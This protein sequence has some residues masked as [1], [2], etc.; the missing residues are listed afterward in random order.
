MI[1]LSDRDLQDFQEVVDWKTG[2]QMPDGRVLGVEGKR[3]KVS[4]GN[5]SRV[6]L[7]K[8]MIDPAH[9]TVL[10]VGCCEGIHTLQLAAVAKHVTALDVRPKNIVCTLT[11]LFVHDI[12]NVSVK[13]ADARFLDAK[14][15]HYD[16]LFHVGV[17]YHLMD[18]VEHLFAIRD[19][20]DSL[21]LDTHVTHADTS[22]PRDDIRHGN[23][24]YRAHLYREGGWADV[25]SGVEPASRWLDQD[26][27]VEV[28]RDAGYA[29]VE[30]VQE[31][32]E[33]NG[34]RVCI[35][36]HRQAQTA[37]HAA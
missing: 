10:E 8:N 21:V 25:F 31:R 32:A 34:P 7:V 22:F 18:P 2:M 27:L 28:L 14:E 37:R 9:G 3:G 12:K 1:T 26:A 20:A 30:V 13:L 4:K 17:L 29:S 6:A 24:T 33:R 15:G 16:V 5:D 19:L 35:V 36:A 23:K 11:R